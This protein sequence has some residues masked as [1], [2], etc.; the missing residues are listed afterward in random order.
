MPGRRDELLDAIRTRAAV[1]K[2][3]RE[4][5]DQRDFVEVTTPCL[6]SAPDPAV[7]LDSFETRV[8]LPGGEQPGDAEHQFA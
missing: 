8:T 7:H 5:F 1:L 6:V 3:I 2:K 4:F